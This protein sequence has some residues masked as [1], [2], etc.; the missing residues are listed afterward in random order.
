MPGGREK[1]NKKWAQPFPPPS[2]NE[3]R[4]RILGQDWNHWRARSDFVFQPKPVQHPEKYE[5]HQSVD[6]SCCL[7]PSFLSENTSFPQLSEE[8]DP[9]ALAVQIHLVYE[10]TVHCR[11]NTCIQYIIYEYVNTLYV[12]VYRHIY[13]YMSYENHTGT[14]THMTRAR[15]N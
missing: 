3:C 8:T 11:L 6:S 1:H 7:H 2:L 13:I 4:A 15:T 9:P 5:K 10:F 14:H 12:C